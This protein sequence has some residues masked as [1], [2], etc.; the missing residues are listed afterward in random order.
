[1][2]LRLG[3]FGTMDRTGRNHMDNPRN[4]CHGMDID[5]N[6]WFGHGYRESDI[7]WDH[8]NHYIQPNIFRMFE[9]ILLHNNM[10]HLW[11]YNWNISIYFLSLLVDR[12]NFQGYSAS[13]KISWTEALD[14]RPGLWYWGSPITQRE[15]P[16]WSLYYPMGHSLWPIA[17]STPIKY[18]LLLEIETSSFYIDQWILIFYRLRPF[19]TDKNNRFILS[20]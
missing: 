13:F 8:Q 19:F 1:M 14:R 10:L 9:H 2:V 15:W 5:R 20:I 7:Q 11:R 16:H 6:M 17:P 12:S 18:C 3:D 4:I